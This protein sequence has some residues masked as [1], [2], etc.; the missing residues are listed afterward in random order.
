MSNRRVD[1]MSRNVTATN[2]FNGEPLIYIAQL[3]SLGSENLLEKKNGFGIFMPISRKEME[4]ICE[5]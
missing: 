3:P 5:K 1:D 4:S 2:V